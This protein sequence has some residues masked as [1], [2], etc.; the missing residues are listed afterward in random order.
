MEQ[1]LLSSSCYYL[2]KDLNHYFEVSLSDE[3]HQL[4]LMFMKSEGLLIYIKLS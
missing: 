3:K 4:S 2:I 1:L